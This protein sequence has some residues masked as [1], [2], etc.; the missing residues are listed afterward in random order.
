MSRGIKILCIGDYHAHFSY[1]NARATAIGQFAAEEQPDVIVQIGD[2]SDVVS[3]NTHG[4]KL[5]LEGVR[6]K[7]DIEATHDALDCL[8][9]PILR[10]KKKLPRRIITLGNHEHRINRWIQQEPR[11]EGTMSV[12]DLGFERFGFDVFPFGREVE[13]AGFDFVHHLGS[14]TGR[15]AAI[16]SPSNGIKSIGKST[17]VGHTHIANHVPVPLKGRMVHGLD[18]GCTIHK[19]MGH[20]ED[21]SHPSAHKY[22]R[23]VWI[24][25]NA[26][27]GDAD[28]REIRL[29]SLGV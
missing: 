5:E 19:D 14:Q 24:L 22:R 2:F 16:T 28:F 20:D 15:A 21:W 12:H 7:D 3:L 10:R 13:I 25:D 17:V 26:A 4:T 1:N 8:M 23:C 6:W 27:D 29:S 11:F 18:L 9:R